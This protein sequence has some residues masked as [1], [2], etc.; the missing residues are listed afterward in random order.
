MIVALILAAGRGERFSAGPVRK[1]F[2]LINGVPMFI[3]AVRQYLDAAV[4]AE[5]VLALDPANMSGAEA[6]LSRYG[7]AGKVEIAPGGATRQESIKAAYHFACDHWP[8]SP[9]DTMILHNAASPNVSVRT[10]QQCIDG[11]RDADLVQAFTPQLRTQIQ[12]GADGVVSVPDRNSLGVTCD[13]T[14]YRAEALKRIVDH[15]ESE[16]LVGDSTIDVA[17]AIGLNIS[18]VKA[19]SGNIK[20][21]TP[22]DLAAIRTAM[23]G[24]NPEESSETRKSLLSGEFSGDR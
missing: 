11:V 15:M 21:T 14:V 5:V 20:V 7:M 16:E 8:I 10:I 19:E 4:A 17:F 23:A 1:Q 9:T 2:E 18:T 6:Q 3:Y 24:K 22:W 12:L 13:P